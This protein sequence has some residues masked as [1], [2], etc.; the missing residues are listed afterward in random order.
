LFWSLFSDKKRLKIYSRVLFG[1]VKPAVNMP[2]LSRRACRRVNQGKEKGF[3]KRS[4]DLLLLSMDRE[5]I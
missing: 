4:Q 5:Y 2:E 3:G 1:G